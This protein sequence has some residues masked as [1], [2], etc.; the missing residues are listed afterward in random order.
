[1]KPIE[2]DGEAEEEYRAAADYYEGQVRGLGF[3]FTAA[4]GD[5]ISRIVQTPKAFSPY[6]ESGLRKFVLQRFPY[7]VY[8]L[9]LDDCIWIAAVANQRRKPGYWHHRH[10]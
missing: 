7:S 4:V 10:P 5:A 3:E 9:E 6:K 2:F 1:M 8:Y